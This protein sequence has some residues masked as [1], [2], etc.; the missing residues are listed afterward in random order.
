MGKALD[1]EVVARRLNQLVVFP[2]D[3]AVFH[4]PAGFEDA[5]PRE[6]R[7]HDDAFGDV[8]E[9]GALVH[10]G[11]EGVFGARDDDFES[12][13]DEADGRIGIEKSEMGCK[14]IGQIFV[15]GIQEC[16]EL[17][18]S[19]AEAGVE[20]GALTRVRL[21][22]DGD[23]RVTRQLSEQMGCRVG[24]AVVDDD[25]PPVLKG[26]A[27]KRFAG[28][29]ERVRGVVS[30]GDDANGRGADSR[31]YRSLVWAMTGEPGGN[32]RLSL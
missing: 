11:D 17:F 32:S 5:T 27:A 23:A 21:P 8:N 16:D 9:A 26:L 25:V 19:V 28:T 22:D 13:P 20:R 15:V 12:T 29:R 4:E 14:V 3:G 2:P 1:T 30:G 18:G 6:D 31:F 10:V 24:A 7:T